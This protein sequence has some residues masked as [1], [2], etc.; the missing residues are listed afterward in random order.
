MNTRS[1]A[2]LPDLPQALE[3]LELLQALPAH[4]PLAPTRQPVVLYGAGELGQMAL[5]WCRQRGVRVLAV[6]DAGASRW[7]DHPAWQGVLVL[8]PQEVPADWRPSHRLLVCISTLA[9]RP[10]EQALQAQGWAVVQPFYDFAHAWPEPQPLNNGWHA[11]LPEGQGLRQLKAVLSGWG[12]ATSR[13]HH[14]QFMA[15]RCKREEWD[16][17]PAPVQPKQRYFI[18]EF[19]ACW[20]P[21]ERLL[22]GGAHHGQV[23]QRWMQERPGW[24]AQAWAVEPDPDNR[25][26]LAQWREGLPPEQQAR[27]GVHAMALGRR[28]GCRPFEPGQGYGS[29]L[30][31]P[32]RSQVAVSALDDLGWA[33]SLVKLHLEGGEW[34]AL[35]GGLQ[36]LRQHR[37]L[38][39]LTVYHRRD[40]L[41][42]T[43][44]WLMR[45]LPDYR[46]LFRLHGWLGTGAVIY[47]MPTERLV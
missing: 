36:T 25:A 21:Q 9:H 45:S 27:I 18:P 16:F 37:P 17:E 44:A 35:Q 14:L 2:D 22:D 5:S 26:V 1:W 6:V 10:I 3:L 13:A 41:H 39:T 38:L 7:V 19:Q 8:A 12:D 43:A 23:L 47:G 20:R 30:W 46:W 32:G 24:L 28:S 15:W 4:Q 11:R 34:R 42:A 29:R 31:A 40:G 33:P